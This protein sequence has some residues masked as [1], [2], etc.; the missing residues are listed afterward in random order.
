MVLGS[1]VFLQG[2]ERF[3]GGKGVKGESVVGVVRRKGACDMYLYCTVMNN[4][5]QIIR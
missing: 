1:F 3:E 2:F 4:F 5:Q